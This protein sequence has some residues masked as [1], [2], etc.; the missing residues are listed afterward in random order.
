[1][2]LNCVNKVLQ[3]LE[4]NPFWKFIKMM[5]SFDATPG[6]F[7]SYFWFTVKPVD[8][9]A[10]GCSDLFSVRESM[11]NKS[12]EN[13][14]VSIFAFQVPAMMIFTVFSEQD[15]QVND[16]DSPCI[17]MATVSSKDGTLK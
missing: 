15:D 11:Q 14:F 9:E 8:W 1:M 3:Y 7:G 6:L 12:G 17:N 2:C 13:M 5:H 4:N 16:E 10:A